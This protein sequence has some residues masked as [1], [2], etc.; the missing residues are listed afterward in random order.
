[1]Y[2]GQVSLG[3][4]HALR[5]A[6][7]QVDSMREGVFAR[8]QRDVVS[9]R[10][11]ADDKI[12]MVGASAKRL[13]REATSRSEGMLREIAGQG[14]EK[15][16]RRGFALVRDKSGKPITRAAQT[17]SSAA[18]EIQFTDGKASATIDKQH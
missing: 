14:P 13:V 4:K 10:A 7:V 1:M 16:L 3:I 18:I 15:T 6:S 17:V 11:D 9:A 5:S 2:W 8:T 12:L